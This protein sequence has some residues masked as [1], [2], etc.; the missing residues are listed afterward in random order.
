MT[1]TDAI[2]ATSMIGVGVGLLVML[3]GGVS[4]VP[5]K[6]GYRI[7]LCGVGILVLSIVTLVVAL[8]V[9]VWSAVELGG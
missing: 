7:F 8:L 3:F 5:E 9:A 2:A 6:V 4:D 1:L